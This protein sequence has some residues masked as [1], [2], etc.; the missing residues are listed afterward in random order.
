MQIIQ[1]GKLLQTKTSSKV[2]TVTPDA[3][4]YDALELMATKDIGA[5][6]V[7]EEGRVVGIFS[8]RDYA[9]KVILKGKSSKTAKVSEMM[10]APVLYTTPETSLEDC[11]RVMTSKRVRHLPVL[12]G[13][14]VVGV[15]SIGDVVKR[16]IADQKYEIRQLEKY[17]SGTGY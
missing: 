16:I 10:S 11:M 2:W 4:V 3:L 15:L 9:R 7:L 13:E 5:V 14:Q 1:V 17:I 6:I 12:D 8:E